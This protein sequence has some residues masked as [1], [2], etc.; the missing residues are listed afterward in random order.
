[1]YNKKPH[2]DTVDISF[3]KMATEQYSEPVDPHDDHFMG[4]ATYL[5]ARLLNTHDVSQDEIDSVH[6]DNPRMNAEARVYGVGYMTSDPTN[7]NAHTI[8]DF[9]GDSIYRFRGSVV[10]TDD[11]LGHKQLYHRLK[12]NDDLQ[13]DILI[14]A[15]E[16][17]NKI[18]FI[19]PS[20]AYAE[21][22]LRTFE[23][24]VYTS[25]VETLEKIR[26]QRTPV[27]SFDTVLRPS[28]DDYTPHFN[29]YIGYLMGIENAATA[30]IA[31]C[32]SDSTIRTATLSEPKLIQTQGATEENTSRLLFVDETLQKTIPLSDVINVQTRK[33]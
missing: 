23:P 1:M 26:S 5:K 13:T 7:C 27:S 19:T 32:N 3:L 14:S 11:I 6:H 12:S 22:I 21:H 29:T 15:H 24:A 17:T 18:D 20:P 9:H 16:E 33:K 10:V 28:N 25:I 2:P 30:H 31:Y 4:R 8:C